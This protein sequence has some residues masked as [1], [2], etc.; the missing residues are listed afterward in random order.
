MLD[1]REVT[2]HQPFDPNLDA[3]I[4]PEPGLNDPSIR[5]ALSRDSGYNIAR[6]GL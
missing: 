1:S 3:L 4:A 2:L 5:L 6:N